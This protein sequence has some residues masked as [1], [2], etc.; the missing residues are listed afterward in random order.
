M[1][2]LRKFRKKYGNRLIVQT[3]DLVIPRGVTTV[4]GVNGSGKSTLFRCV[5]GIIPYEGSIELFGIDQRSSPVKYRRRVSFSEAKPLF[6]GFLSGRDISSFYSVARSIKETEVA[7]LSHA[8]GVDEF[9]NDKIETYSEGMNKK[10]S[11]MLA[12]IGS[13]DLIVLDEPFAFLDEDSRGILISLIKKISESEQR[14]FLIS[15]HISEY[16][17]ELTDCHQLRLEN[18]SLVPEK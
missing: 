18:H 11:L 15:N 17:H 12:F 1:L 13:P 7:D 4:R 2:Q 16:M 3:D 8:L 6:P 9:L 5:A 10:L 14:N